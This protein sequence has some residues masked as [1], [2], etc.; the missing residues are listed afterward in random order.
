MG[1][2]LLLIG[3]GAGKFMPKPGGW[4]ES[5]TRIFGIVMLGVAIWLLDRVL[6]ATIIIYLWALLLLGSAIYL[7]IYQHI[8]TQL[9]TVVLFI[10]GVFLS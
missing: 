8:L 7:K 2:P 10:L 4:M 6:D 1:V 9:I 3:L 5:I